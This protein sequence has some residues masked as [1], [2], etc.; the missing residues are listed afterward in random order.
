MGDE[1]GGEVE[2]ADSVDRLGDVAEEVVV[3]ALP[4]GDGH[5]GGD[6]EANGVAGEGHRAECFQALCDAGGAALE[7]A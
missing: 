4:V 3:L 6:G 7:V 2:V 5:D 1:L